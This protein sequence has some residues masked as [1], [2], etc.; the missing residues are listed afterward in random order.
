METRCSGHVHYCFKQ[1]FFI[2]HP[3]VSIILSAEGLQLS[4]QA[5]SSF[6]RILNCIIKLQFFM[7]TDRD[8]WYEEARAA[9]RRRLS[10]DGSTGSARPVA[11]N[12]ILFVG[13]GMGLATI[14]A[15]RI[16]RGQRDGRPG[17]ETRLAWE[18]FPA[19]AL[20]R[21]SATFVLPCWL[22]E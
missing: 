19:V 9:L 22:S 18:H 10:S 1:C 3:K 20:A 17:E 2:L 8:F 15:S 5:C 6:S 13:D 14:T 4:E 7:F 21:V 11:R 16:L 12:V